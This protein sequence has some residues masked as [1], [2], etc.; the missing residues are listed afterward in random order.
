MGL[1]NSLEV[2]RDQVTNSRSQG[3]FQLCQE[4]LPRLLHHRE[5]LLE[6]CVQVL[7]IIKF[8]LVNWA[9]RSSARIQSTCLTPPALYTAR[10]WMEHIFDMATSAFSQSS[11]ESS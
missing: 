1:H 4:G 9:M 7:P 11:A 5:Q 10:R 3:S 8:T 2:V 6:A